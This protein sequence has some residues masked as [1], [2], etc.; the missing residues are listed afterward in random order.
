[1]QRFRMEAQNPVPRSSGD[2]PARPLPTIF[3]NYNF[4][5]TTAGS[6]MQ[7]LQTCRGRPVPESSGVIQDYRQSYN[8][9]EAAEVFQS[10]K[11]PALP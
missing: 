4:L 2:L 7:G 3:K 5:E 1:M 11:C 8:D 10:I 6:L 9:L